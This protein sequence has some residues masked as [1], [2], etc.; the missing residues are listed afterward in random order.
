MATFAGLALFFSRGFTN[1]TTMD[2][3]LAEDMKF[4]GSVG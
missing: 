2:W 4:L 1:S 3:L